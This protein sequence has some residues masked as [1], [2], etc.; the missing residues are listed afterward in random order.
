[1]KSLLIALTL[2]LSSQAFAKTQPISALLLLS[3]E[4][5]FSGK[6]G[7][8]DCE[9][10][11]AQ[12]TENTATVVIKNENK[13]ALFNLN[14]NSLNYSFDT[15]TYTLSAT[16]SLRSPF[17]LNGGTLILTVKPTNEAVN[18]SISLIALDHKGNDF[19]TFNACS[20]LR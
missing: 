15:E 9:V 14:N 8:Q 17:Y 19:S 2:A 12:K 18:F 20:V 1:M 5:T 10:V 16:D 7:K 3:P 6:N 11:V 13:T 4:G